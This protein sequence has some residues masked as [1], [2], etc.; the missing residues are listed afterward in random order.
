MDIAICK[1]YTVLETDT[2]NNSITRLSLLQSAGTTKEEKDKGKKG[3]K[4]K[5]KDEPVRKPAPQKPPQKPR[6]VEAAAKK[7]EQT[8]GGEDGGE[9]QPGEEGG[10]AEQEE[11]VQD[12]LLLDTTKIQHQCL[13]CTMSGERYLLRKT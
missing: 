13:K 1:V 4:G 12:T 5:G 6:N 9:R 11:K 10:P 3:K 8:G 7:T 2:I